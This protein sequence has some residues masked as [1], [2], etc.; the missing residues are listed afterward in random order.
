[1][2]AYKLDIHWYTSKARLAER[3]GAIRGLQRGTENVLE[4]SD[5][6]VPFDVG[7]PGL[8]SSGETFV[9]PV[10]LRGAVSYDTAYAAFQHEDLTLHHEE[11]R[12]AKYLE[13]VINDPLVKKQTEQ[14]IGE[15]I[16]KEFK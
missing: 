6:V 5:R 3:A 7:T 4:K 15:E 1:M 16:K 2:M 14:L 11:G 9:D 10:E 8:F 13:D 12:K